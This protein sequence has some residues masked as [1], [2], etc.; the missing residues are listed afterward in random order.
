MGSKIDRSRS[1]CMHVFRADED[2]LI[3]ISW[4]SETQSLTSWIEFFNPDAIILLCYICFMLGD[5]L[6]S[7]VLIK[8]SHIT[9]AS[10]LYCIM[11]WNHFSF[12]ANQRIE[13]PWH[14]PLGPLH[15][16][17]NTN[18]GIRSPTTDT[19]PRRRGRNYSWPIVAFWPCQLKY[20]CNPSCMYKVR[21]SKCTSTLT[22]MINQL[23][24]IQGSIGHRHNGDI[25]SLM[26][27]CY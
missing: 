7:I 22:R 3:F 16:S 4:G 5:S 10:Q 9:C 15:T 13:K 11:C 21:N 6:L 12:A 24:K 18:H 2:N 14:P 25:I 23:N 27:F 1:K 26:I 19:S 8:W 17:H 20:F